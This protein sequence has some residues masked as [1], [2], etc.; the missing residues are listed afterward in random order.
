MIPYRHEI[1]WW[2]T[3]TGA[4][5]LAEPATQP[6]TLA[7]LD[8]AVTATLDSIL[9]FGGYNSFVDG[10][11]KE[12]AVRELRAMLGG[13]HRPAP[14]DVEDYARASGETDVEGARRL[15]SFNEK[16]LAGRQLRDYRGRAI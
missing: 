6:V 15:R 10:G 5:N 13:G 7:S 9:A 3:R 2:I 8:P 16:V 11:E 14:S 12:E 1:T 4:V